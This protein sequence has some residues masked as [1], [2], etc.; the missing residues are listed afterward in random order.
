MN[1]T[2]KANLQSIAR[3]VINIA[4][5]YFAFSPET[6]T[7]LEAALAVLCTIVWT[8]WDN[9]KKPQPAPVVPTPQTPPVLPLILVSCLI[10]G[11]T[12]CATGVATTKNI[13]TVAK[14]AA[15]EG[16]KYEIK[17][18]PGSRRY[19]VAGRDALRG[20]LSSTNYNPI[21]FKAALQTLP[22]KELKS[23]EA[24]LLLDAA[25]TL[26]E[27]YASRLTA[28]DSEEKVKP[29]MEAVEVGLTMAIEE[30]KP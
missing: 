1:D 6:S 5:G 21:A 16:S 25:V 18:D 13:A 11:A 10:I 27:P 23:S 28:L 29:V 24:T 30:T 8:I 17:Q 26:W 2:M 7:K 4:A 15:Y 9:S 12:G 3:A 20:L 22:I 14:I 19:F